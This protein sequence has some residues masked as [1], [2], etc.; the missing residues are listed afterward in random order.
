MTFRKG[1]RLDPRQVR[2]LRGSRGGLAIGGGL[3][4]VVLVVIV[5]LLGGSPQDASTLTTV[6]SD[7]TV[8]TQQENDL[9]EECQTDVD[10]NTREDCRIIGY[11]NSIQAYWGEAVDGYQLAPTTF[12][13]DAVSTGCGQATSAVGPFYCPVDATVYIDLGFFDLLE[14]RFGAEGGPFAEA[15]VIAHEY[16]HHVQN[17]IGVLQE[18]GGAGAESGAV[19]TELQADCFAGVWAANAVDTGY[20]V[21][22]TTQQVAQA[23]DAAAA[24]GDDRIQAQTQGQVN[25]ETWTHGSSAQRQEWFQVGLESGDPNACNTFEADL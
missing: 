13:T 10:A 12:F 25:P 11:V 8:G 22:L 3:G 18:S 17:L 21:P 24:V 7:L 1:I 9:T 19:R 5:L 20:L 4:G 23:L 16:G 15:Y 6:L 2:D 14:S